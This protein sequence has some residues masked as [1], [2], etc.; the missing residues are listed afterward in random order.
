MLPATLPV[1]AT[2]IPPVQAGVV[3][4]VLYA[5]VGPDVMPGDVPTLVAQQRDLERIIVDEGHP[6]PVA[7]LLEIRRDQVHDILLDLDD[8]DVLDLGLLQNGANRRC[9]NLSLRQRCRQRGQPNCQAR[10]D[11]D[12]SDLCHDPSSMVVLR[13]TLE[14]AGL[15]GDAEKV[16]TAGRQAQRSFRKIPLP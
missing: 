9:T 1:H 5:D 10:T 7:L 11:R 12:E 8:I 13:L 6:A 2:A 14:Q 16:Y 4:Q 3:V 15:G